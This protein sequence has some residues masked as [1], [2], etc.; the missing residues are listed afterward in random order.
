LARGS[1]DAHVRGFRALAI[2]YALSCLLIAPALLQAD[3]LVA[4]DPP[5]APDAPAAEQ[6]PAAEP[7]P[8]PAP[9]PAAPAEDQA[10]VVVEQEAEEPAAEGAPAAGEAKATAAKKQ[11]AGE[12]VAKVAASGSVT[13]SDFKFTPATIT[14]NVGDTITWT[15]DGPTPHSATAKDGSFDTGI[16]DKGATGS[17]TFDEA[18][19]IAYICTP[20]P[21]MK[22]TVIVKAASSGGGG[23]SSGDTSDD[24]TSDDSTATT[25]DDDSDDLPNTGAET[26]AIALLG[27]A[28]LGAGL[29]M[30]R[31]QD[32][33]S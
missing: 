10:P 25:D 21:Y 18:G 1:Y 22:G 19:T 30:R 11:S 5:A 8:A 12:P 14:V 2:A 27:L 9:P 24:D 16:L 4:D 29:L 23:T 15:N 32:A 26:L 3:T 28:T 33:G 6:A 31:R 13:I 20:H 7:T 17:A